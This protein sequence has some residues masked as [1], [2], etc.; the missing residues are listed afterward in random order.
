MRSKNE[1]RLILN[2]FFPIKDTLLFS[3]LLETLFQIAIPYSNQMTLSTTQRIWFQFHVSWTNPVSSCPTACKSFIITINAHC[4]CAS[5]TLNTLCLCSLPWT[6]F[7]TLKLHWTILQTVYVTLSSGALFPASTQIFN[8]SIASISS[9]LFGLF[10]P[11]W[12][13][14]TSD[15]DMPPGL[16]QSP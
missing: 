2:I 12:S 10:A 8:I 15:P 16:Y 13:P 5:S 4:L 1:E 11:I 14:W 6:R 3:I 7:L 9:I